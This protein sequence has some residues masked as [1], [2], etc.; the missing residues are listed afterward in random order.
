MNGSGRVIGGPHP[1][2]GHPS[3]GRGVGF[4]TGRPAFG[5][6]LPEGEGLDLGRIAPAFGHPLPEGEGLDL[7][8]VAPAFGHPLPEGEGFRI[9]GP[10]VRGRGVGFRTGLRPP[11]PRGRGVGFGTDR[12]GLRPP[13]P[14]GETRWIWDGSH[15]HSATL[16][17]RERGFDTACFAG[18]TISGAVASLGWGF[19]TAWKA[20]IQGQWRGAMAGLPRPLWISALM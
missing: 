14:R 20:G 7:G 16:S 18:M 15:R 5:H 6:P 2:F 13:S 11:S 8:R 10:S 9:S 17:Q 4:G 12:T 1:A 19:D 3:R